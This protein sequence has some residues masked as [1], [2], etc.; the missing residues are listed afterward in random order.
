M[1]SEVRIEKNSE[2]NWISNIK[3]NLVLKYNIDNDVYYTSPLSKENR[4]PWYYK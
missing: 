3:R 1:A 4:E 2:K